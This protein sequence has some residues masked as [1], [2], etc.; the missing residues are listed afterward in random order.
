MVFKVPLVK[1]V[2]KALKEQ[3]DLKVQQVRMVQKGLEE[4]LV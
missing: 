4:T 1:Q 3:E 2:L